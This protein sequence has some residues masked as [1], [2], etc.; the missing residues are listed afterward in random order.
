VFGEVFA[1]AGAG[2]PRPND[3]G[4]AGEEALALGAIV[5]AEFAE[6]R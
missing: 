3:T 5:A 1:V 4:E 2:L 6:F